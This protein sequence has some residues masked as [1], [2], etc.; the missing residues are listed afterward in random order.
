MHPGQLPRFPESVVTRV[1]P[2]A[3]FFCIVDEQL[4]LPKWVSHIHKMMADSSQKWQDT[5]VP[6]LIRESLGR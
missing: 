3:L 2:L 6:G 4:R 5:Q 1:A